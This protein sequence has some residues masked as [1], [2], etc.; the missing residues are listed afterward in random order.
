MNLPKAI[1]LAE[2]F[3]LQGTTVGLVPQVDP[4]NDKLEAHVSIEVK[5]PVEYHIF[6]MIN[7]VWNH[8]G[9]SAYLNGERLTFK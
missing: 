7:D 2:D 4:V 5:H 1:K 8:Y 6:N 3:L 9:A